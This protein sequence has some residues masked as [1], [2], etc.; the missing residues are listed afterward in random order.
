MDRGQFQIAF[1]F[2]PQNFFDGV[3]N[4]ISSG[5]RMED[6][7]YQIAYNKQELRNVI[8]EYPPK[9][10]KICYGLFELLQRYTA[11]MSN[12]YAATFP[13]FYPTTFPH[14]IRNLRRSVTIPGDSDQEPT[15]SIC[16]KFAGPT[17]RIVCHLLIS[18]LT[19]EYSATVEEKA[20]RSHWTLE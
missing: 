2:S 10:V 7:G 8:K 5:V 15:H 13:N 1:V 11:Y 19:D 4:C 18:F 16:L 17:M 12:F 3:E 20:N 14:R 6:V 9:E